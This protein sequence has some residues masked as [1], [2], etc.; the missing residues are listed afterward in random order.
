[1]HAINPISETVKG[2]TCNNLGSCLAP[3]SFFC[4]WW[5]SSNEVGDVDHRM[6]EHLGHLSNY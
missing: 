5:A 2:F 1:M 3:T 4:P 6:A